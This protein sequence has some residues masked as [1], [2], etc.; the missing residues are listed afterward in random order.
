[1][2]QDTLLGA[3]EELVLLA[4]AHLGGQAYGMQVRR[5]IERRS[6]RE[7]AIGAVYATLERMQEKGFL[8]SQMASG[9]GERRGRPRKFFSLQPTGLQALRHAQRLHEKMWKGIDA[10]VLDGESEA[11]Q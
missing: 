8:A 3:F 5:E 11:S 10:A 7:V 4:L 2:S 6:G 1:M 9:S